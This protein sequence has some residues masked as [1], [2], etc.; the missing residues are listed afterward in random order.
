MARSGGNGEFLFR[1]ACQPQ[2]HGEYHSIKDEKMAAIPKIKKLIIKNFGCVGNTPIELDIDRIVV[3]VGANNSGK[4][5]ILRAFEVVTESSKLEVDDFHNRQVLADNYPEIEIHSI[6]T[7]ENKPGDEWCV[8]LP[9]SEFLVR[10]R[11][12]WLGVNVEPTRTGYNVDLDRWPEK[13]DKEKMPWGFNA[14]AKS[15]RPKPHRVNTFDNPVDQS[16]AIISLLKSLLEDNIKTLK[17]SDEAEITRYDEIVNALTEL[18]KDGKA[19]QKDRINELEKQANSILDKIFPN[20]NIFFSSKDGEAPISVDLLGDE[21]TVEMGPQG[22]AAFPLAK[23][24]SGT[25]RTA[26]WAILKLLADQGY[27]AKPN[28]RKGHHEELGEVSA[29]VLLLDEPEVSLHP[30]AVQNARDV[31]YSLPDS[32]NWQV[33]ITTH[34]PSFIDL[35]KDHTTII[36][37]E[38]NSQNKIEATTL[39]RPDVAQLDNDDKENLKLMNLFDSHISEAF[40]GG[41]ILIVEG[42]TE[43]SAFNYIKSR[44]RDNG[45][46]K[47]DDLNIIRARGKVTV[48]SMMKVL[49]HFKATYFVIHDTDRP[50]TMSRKFKGKDKAGNR[51]YEEIEINNPAWT[52]NSKI[53]DQMSGYSKVA[54]SIVN[55]EVAYFAETADSGK[56]ENCITKMKDSQE[57]YDTVKNLIDGILEDGELPEGAI[58]WK[59][60]EELKEAIKG[61]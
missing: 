25:Q 37:V 45:S 15:R 35:T 20:N 6:A 13:A 8:K 14:V 18:K 53:L 3:L 7:D 26:L 5:T 60:I 29:H 19:G 4:S 28:G 33:M 36:R 21:F 51:I 58:R 34:S 56:P 54:A 49:N 48:A 38:K 31:L 59:S 27:K 39:F 16:K 57:H 47:Y 40:F 11:W 10:E 1:S 46:S 9:N 44:E 50:K 30:K 2:R 23:Q 17:A 61:W 42:D 41:R 12:Q 52:N 43:Y 24:G 32:E 55:F 22:G